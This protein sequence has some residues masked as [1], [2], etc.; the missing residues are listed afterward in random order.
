MTVSPLPPGPRVPNSRV[1]VLLKDALDGVPDSTQP[2]SS[3]GGDLL[4]K[5]H[6]RERHWTGHPIGD[7][8][9]LLLVVTHGLL[10]ARAIL[11]VGADGMA[12]K[13]RT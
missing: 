2:G 10:G 11:P 5:L 9:V 8:P 7:E 6:V 13:R 4:E 12:A 3:I 1:T